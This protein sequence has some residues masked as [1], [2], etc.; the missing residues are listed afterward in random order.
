VVGISP[1]SILSHEKFR[2]K[3][4]ISVLLLSDPDRLT[5]EAYG[6]LGRKIAYGK[7]SFGVIRSTVLIDPQGIVRIHWPRVRA[8]GHAADVLKSLGKANAQKD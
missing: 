2:R 7:E 5:I 3:H 8:R 6:A 4:N 1:D